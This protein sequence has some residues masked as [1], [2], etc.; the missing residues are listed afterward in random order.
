[1]KK[2]TSGHKI[3]KSKEHT[4]AVVSAA[5]GCT[6]FKPT[7]LQKQEYNAITSEAANLLCIQCTKPK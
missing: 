1:V 5:R 6:P 2:I 7:T 3:C 4:A